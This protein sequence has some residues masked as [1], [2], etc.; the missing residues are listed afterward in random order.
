MQ[1][2][3]PVRVQCEGDMTVLMF[4]R[5][6]SL[7]N[8]VTVKNSYLLSA[9]EEGRE[10]LSCQTFFALMEKKLLKYSQYRTSRFFL[11]SLLMKIFAF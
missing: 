1:E 8:N 6:Y 9:S 10:K 7:V 4:P 3:Q 5:I 2:Y 11:G